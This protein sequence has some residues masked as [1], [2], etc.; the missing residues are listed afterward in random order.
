MAIDSVPNSPHPHP[1]GYH[2]TGPHAYKERKLVDYKDIVFR[3]ASDNWFREQPDYIKPDNPMQWPLRH[4][5]KLD[6]FVPTTIGKSA[7][8]EF[9]DWTWPEDA[10]F[11][12][13]NGFFQD[14]V[15]VLDVGSGYGQV[16]QQINKE[17]KDK[18]ITAIGVDYRYHHDRPENADKLIAGNVANLPFQ[19]NSFNRLLSVESF[20]AWYPKNR[21]QVSKYFQEITRVS[22]PGAIWRGTM[23]TYDD[24]ETPYLSN[25][26]FADIFTQN[27]WELVIDRGSIAFMAKLVA[28]SQS[29]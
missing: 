20:P 10:I 19:S 16:V 28:K 12:G 22:Q 17:F 2:D 9:Y 23:P 5:H 1:E 24:F 3:D 21:E 13:Y 15:K 26:E 27:G 14:N 18:Q 7:K 6:H 29:T 4:F 25:D 8:Q 11:G